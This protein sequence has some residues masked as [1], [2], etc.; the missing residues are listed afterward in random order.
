MDNYYLTS[1]EFFELSK[2][3]IL[4]TNENYTPNIKEQ[5]YDMLIDSN[6]QFT[7]GVIDNNKYLLNSVKLYKSIL[8]LD[9]NRIS[10]VIFLINVIHFDTFEDLT[11]W[12]S[13]TTNIKN[14]E[15]SSNKDN[16]IEP[17]LSSNDKLS[18][19]E[20]VFQIEKII[21]IELTGKNTNDEGIKQRKITSNRKRRMIE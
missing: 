2:E 10:N 21:D 13:K 9:R 4:V 14:F 18:S 1:K 16:D 12:I 15:K 7:I 17:K 11:K 6:I 8:S 20:K 5:L 3:I 19:N